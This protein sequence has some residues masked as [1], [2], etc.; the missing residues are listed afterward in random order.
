MVDNRDFNVKV[1]PWQLI[2][3]D[4]NTADN[5]L[6]SCSDFGYDAAG[7]EYGRECCKYIQVI[8]INS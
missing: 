6:S 1:L 7:M 8:S 4:N 3:A 5:C 2:L